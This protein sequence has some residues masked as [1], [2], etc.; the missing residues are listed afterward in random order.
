MASEVKTAY[1]MFGRFNPPTIGHGAVFRKIVDDAKQNG[2]DAFAFVSNTKNSDKNPLT[3]DQKMYYLE[4]LYGNLGIRFINT[5]T[6][7]LGSKTGPC[8][9][10]SFA[11]ERLRSAGYDK[12]V[13]YAGSDRIDDVQWILKS[14][15]KKVEKK[16]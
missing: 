13:L 12:I 10:P 9:N 3:V 11:V 16:Y 15:L 8:K 1:F 5:T 7:E 4:K 6:C 2:A 14:D